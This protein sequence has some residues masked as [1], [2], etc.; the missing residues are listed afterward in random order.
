MAN[1]NIHI[2]KIVPIHQL[3]GTFHIPDYQRGY[4]WQ[5]LQVV[6][7]IEDIMHNPV[8]Q[9]YYLQPITVIKRPN[10]NNSTYNLIDGQQSLTTLLLIYKALQQKSEEWAKLN[11]LKKE[12]VSEH[13]SIC[14][15]TRTESEDFIKNVAT[16]SGEEASEFP[17]VCR[18]VSV[19]RC[20]VPIGRNVC[21]WHD[22]DV[23]LPDEFYSISP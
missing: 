1:D 10:E 14:Y 4:R 23:S 3:E 2:L 13:Y 12:L 17:D 7:L 5:R 19:P 8:G 6:Q 15:D 11:F 18:G 21:A 16:K 22:S 9:S 20:G